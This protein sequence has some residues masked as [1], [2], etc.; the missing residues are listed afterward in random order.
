[1]E[2]N[3]RVACVGLD[4]HKTFSRVTARDADQRIL[5]RGRWEHRDRPKLRR[6]LRQLPAGTP[7]VLEGTFGWAW[8]ADEIEAAE[9]RPSLASSRKVA[10]WRK[11]RGLAK[12]NRLD[13]DLLSELPGER[14]RWWAIWLP[15]PAV[16]QR[17]EWL[18]YRMTLV[19]IQTGLKNRI[20]AL[21]HQHGIILDVSDL[22]GAAGR[23]ALQQLLGPGAQRLPSE[24][25]L[26]LRGYLQLLDH[27]RRQIAAVLRIVRR[28]VTQSPV[29]ERL[30]QLPGIAY[31]L[32]HTIAAE[33]GDFSR[34]P[35]ARH[36]ASYSLLAP[37]AN[38]SGDDDE[39]HPLGRHLGHAGRRT[40][41]WAWLEAA[42]GAVRSGGFWR[43]FFDA[44]TDGGTRNRQHGYIRV[45]HRLCTVAFACQRQQSDYRA[46]P[47]PR[48]GTRRRRPPAA[49][50]VPAASRRRATKRP[51]VG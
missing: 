9:L 11:A 25:Q 42:H 39:S 41:K 50:P 13:A 51:G 47:P 36:L 30:R 26:V 4:C 1:M 23:R 45:A 19:R 20:H 37:R 27:V 3:E 2:T 29:A 7:V 18:R 28:Q 12:C 17:R 46:D 33:V 40:L 35:T 22:F 10:A 48:P 6:I 49:A 24:T 16:R 8:M 44:H 43:Q 15:P 21:L 34:F 31:I 14:S 32:A 38:E 5:W